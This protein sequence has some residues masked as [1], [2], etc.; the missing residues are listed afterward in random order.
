MAEDPAVV[1]VTNRLTIPV[2]ELEWRFTRSGGP[3]GQ[4]ANTSDTR[5]EVRFDVTG[6]P[7]LSEGQ[8]ARLLERVGPEVRVVASDRR[9][10]ARNR[11]LALERLG[12]R[13]AEAVAVEAPRRATRP[14][15]ASVQRR[16]EAKRRRSQRKAGRR[17]VDPD[18]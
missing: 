4:H 18:G 8:R 14:S 15:R 5:V 1:R 2:A 7:S 12:E 6:S 17:R 9:S 11:Q 3:G 13:L 10:Q 16:L